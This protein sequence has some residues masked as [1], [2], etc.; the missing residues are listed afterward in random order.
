MPPTT[1]INIVIAGSG[2][3]IQ[4]PELSAVLFLA[5]AFEFVSLYVAIFCNVKRG[6]PVREWNL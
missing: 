5:A 6:L 3:D 1:L 4:R 2:R